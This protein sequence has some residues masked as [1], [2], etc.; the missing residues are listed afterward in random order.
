MLSRVAESLTWMGRYLERAEGLA[1]LVEVSEQLALDVRH[2]E[3][4][5]AEAFFLPIVRTYRLEEFLPEAD[6]NADQLIDFLLVGKD[7]PGSVLASLTMARQNA[8]MVRDQL[9]TEFWEV[10][11]DVYLWCREKSVRRKKVN[12]VEMGM[13]V[14]QACLHFRGLADEVLERSEAWCFLKLGMKLERADQTSRVLDLR[15][16]MPSGGGDVSK[17]FEPYVWLAIMRGCGAQDQRGFGSTEP[18]WPRAVRTLV[19][20][21]VFP[22]SIRHCVG[23]IS[24]VLHELSGTRLGLHSNEAERAC[25]RLLAEL[26]LLAYSGVIKGDLHDFLDGVQ[27]G[28]N[29]IGQGI[30]EAY[31]YQDPETVDEEAEEDEEEPLVFSQKQSQG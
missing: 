6:L 27:R 15:T 17:A 31:S 26:D 30:Y 12:P 21:N 10:L 3:L 23:R 13:R 8:R 1:R 28:L 4:S 24:E 22:R 11:N 29:R 14:R 19:L 20:S 2:G 18:D 25:G 5:H 16:F 9:G 7:N